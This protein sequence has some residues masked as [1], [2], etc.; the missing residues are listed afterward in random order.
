MK[1]WASRGF[2]TH[3]HSARTSKLVFAPT[4]VCPAVLVD[5]EQQ[6]M[7]LLYAWWGTRNPNVTVFPRIRSTIVL[8]IPV[9]VCLPFGSSVFIDVHAFRNVGSRKIRTGEEPLLAMLWPRRAFWPQSVDNTLNVNIVVPDSGNWYYNIPNV[10][11]QF[12]KG[13]IFVE[14]KGKT[15]F[16]LDYAGLLKNIHLQQQAGHTA[17]LALHTN[18]VTSGRPGL[19]G[20]R[21]QGRKG[22]VGEQ[23]RSGWIG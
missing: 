9:S 6:L 13:R 5:N 3:S 11:C 17:F 2:T 23:G 20:A 22:R 14:I 4:R 18:I 12:E 19:F 1:Y 21:R 10:S 15:Y 8:N 7:V 16:E